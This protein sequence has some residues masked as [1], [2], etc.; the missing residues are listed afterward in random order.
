MA[1][2]AFASLEHE[3]VR[4]VIPLAFGRFAVPVSRSESIWSRAIWSSITG[5]AAWSNVMLLSKGK[6]DGYEFL[7]MVQLGSYLLPLVLS[8]F[9]PYPGPPPAKPVTA[10]FKC[11][12]AVAVVAVLSDAVATFLHNDPCM[13]LRYVAPVCFIAR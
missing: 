1:G 6:L 12:A 5:Y 2:I 8:Y 3:M 11:A 9:L 4:V 13:A 10:V 7:F